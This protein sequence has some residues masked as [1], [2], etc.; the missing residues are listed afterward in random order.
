[1]KAFWYLVLVVVLTGCFEISPDNLNLYV[2]NSPVTLKFKAGKAPYTYQYRFRNGTQMESSTSQNQVQ[3]TETQTGLM[4]VTATDADG[5]S[6]NFDY[7]ITSNPRFFV[8]PYYVYPTDLGFHQEHVDAIE[9]AMVEV[10]EF[11]RQ[12]TGIQFRVEDVASVAGPNYAQM[13]CGPSLPS[14]CVSDPA[15]FPG[16]QT[17]L[18][19]VLGGAGY[20]EHQVSLL[21]VLGG[22]GQVWGI[23][24]DK[25]TI[26]YEGHSIVG[27]WV[28]EP[29]SGIQTPGSYHCGLAEPGTCTRDGAI[30][31]VIHELGHGLGLH[32]PEVGDREGSVMY[33]HFEYPNIGFND[34]EIKALKDRTFFKGPRYN[35]GRNTKLY[36]SNQN[37]LTR[38]STVTLHG[39]GFQAGNQV[40][41]VHEDGTTLINPQV[42][43]WFQIRFTVPQEVKSGYI[44]VVRANGD[45]TNSVNFNV[46]N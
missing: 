45:R 12:K 18:Q 38:G 32:H 17:S 9:A 20:P 21:F 24:R 27:D 16:W 26:N 6:S 35:E 39:F 22:G 37:V 11:Y 3:L 4:E 15:A 5:N 14:A 43:D 1:M 13:R 42:L 33:Y 46:V 41:F 40:L 29:L 31:A 2:P 8:K 28:L 36:F 30:G 44:L 23:L 7:E 19:T 10:R 25:N 34:Y